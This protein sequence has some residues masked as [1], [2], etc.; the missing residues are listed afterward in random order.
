MLKRSKL[1]YIVGS[2]AIGV[3]CVLVVLFGL[4]AGGAVSGGGAK[5]IFASE[6]AEKVYDGKP[7]S[8]E[9]W[10][11]VG[12]K[13][14]KGYTVKAVFAA[15]RTDAGTSENT[16]SVTVA[17]GDGA[18]KTQDY[19]IEYRFGKLTVSPLQISISTDPASKVYDGTPL[20]RS[21]YRITKGNVLQGHSLSLETTGSITE[22]GKADNTFTALVRD[23]E[24]KDVTDNYEF[25]AK[26]GALTVQPKKISLLSD[27][28]VK[29]YDGTPLTCENWKLSSDSALL[30][31]H[32]ISA[33][34][35]GSQTAVGQGKNSLTDVLIADGG[36]DVTYN[37]SVTLLPGDLV[38]T[39]RPLTV[40]SASDSKLYDGS[41]LTNENWEIVSETKP[42]RGQTAHVAISGTR[43]EAGE[44]PNTIAE[45]VVT[46]ADGKD[47]SSNY[48][49]RLQEGALVVK[50]PDDG[51]G[52]GS[53]GGSGGGL[54]DGGEIGGQLPDLGKITARIYSEKTGKIYLRYTS[55]GDYAFN[56]WLDARAYSELLDSKY[57]FN[58]LTGVAL[59]NAGFESITAKIDPRD[60]CYLL[61]AYPDKD[62]YDYKI[63]TSDVRYDGPVSGVYSLYYYDYDYL[64]DGAEALKGRL[65]SYGEAELR[66]R[67]YVYDS[68]LYLPSSTKAYFEALAS[69]EGF[70]RE[71][72]AIAAAA[73][74]IRGAASYNLRYDKGLDEAADIAVSFLE[75]YR[76]GVCRH[77]ATAA[78]AL[79]RAMGFPARYVVG[80]LGRTEA[81]EWTSVTQK[82]AHAWVEVY[83]D[84]I[85]WVQVEVTGGSG[86]SEVKK[87]L[88]IAPVDLSKKYDGITP[89]TAGTEL[90]GLTALLEQGYTYAAE[91]SGSRLEVGI[92]ESKIES[93]TL[94][95]PQ[96][97]DVTQKFSVTFKK[98]RL[99]VYVKEIKISTL[100][101]SKIYDGLP[102]EVAS[103][104]WTL[105]G[106]LIYGHSIG[107]FALRAAP[108]NA[109]SYVNSFEIVILDEKG[110]DATYMYKIVRECGTLNIGVREIMLVAGSAGKP[111]DGTP[112]TCEEYEL[113]T[114]LED[115]VAL[116]KGDRI[117]VTLSGSQ[118]EIGRSENTVV[119]VVVLNAAG[120][121]VTANYAIGYQN[122]ELRVTPA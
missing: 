29:V 87:D 17:D 122:G 42:A 110:R 114:E 58:Y 41:P 10:N 88:T 62:E 121:D 74:Y 113:T 94:Y 3:V 8:C 67:R 49:L 31:G 72:D 86:D 6:S 111:Y 19:A 60:D 77:Y 79:Y 50:L 39:P 59:E 101:A 70:A 120:E 99:H 91:V 119:K 55:Y 38:V 92:G 109:G 2:V 115:G 96:G 36:K 1:I 104:G 105:D 37:Y 103:D 57:C 63:Q 118:T 48:S 18:D 66:Y 100:S 56:R 7:L 69:R 35:S 47:V 97:K 15:K 116:G 108:T 106:D 98:G 9:K 44:S 107:K 26:L 85:G 80:Y 76:E 61:P 12:G 112:L 65:G 89:L 28:A 78:T 30:T 20:T 64:S 117:S 73:A 22:A 46:D 33:R 11:L 51:S 95:D 23:A 43:T 83:L 16:F 14:K 34:A 21:G 84:G 75:T 90:T 54:S 25:I 52:G 81:G 82:D 45:V 68:Y 32:K 40:R 53:Q 102:L 4:I 71:R 27:T 24:G 93:F 5:L 13:L